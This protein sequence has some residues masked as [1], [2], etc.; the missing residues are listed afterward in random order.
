[1]LFRSAALDKLA[2]YICGDAPLPFPYRSSSKLTELLG[3]FRTVELLNM[4]S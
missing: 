4:T 3:K 2:S 1:M